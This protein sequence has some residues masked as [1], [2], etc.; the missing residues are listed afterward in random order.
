[1]IARCCTCGPLN[2]SWK[3]RE[4]I[5]EEEQV[6]L[7]LMDRR[8]RLMEE[9]EELEARRDACNRPLPAVPA[10]TY[11]AGDD[12]EEEAVIQLEEEDLIDMVA[13]ERGGNSHA[14]GDGNVQ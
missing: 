4:R 11:E 13:D 3:L 12:V 7:V 14:A 9:N 2:R 10:Q 8:R 1:L 5:Q 6:L